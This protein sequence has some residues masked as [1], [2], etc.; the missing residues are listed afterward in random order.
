M[1]RIVVAV[2]L[3]ASAELAQPESAA[4]RPPPRMVVQGLVPDGLH[5]ALNQTIHV[6]LS[7]LCS[8]R[9][10]ATVTRHCHGEP[11]PKLL[12]CCGAILTGNEPF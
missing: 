7:H 2:A 10:R 5:G 3:L 6:L 1:L 12:G 11:V 9:E 4:M 8:T